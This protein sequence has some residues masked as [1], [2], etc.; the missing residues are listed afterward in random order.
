MAVLGYDK[1]GVG[2]STGDWNT[3]SFDDLAG[4]VVA[5][6]DYLKGRRDIRLRAE[7][8]SSESVRPAGSC[9]W[10]PHASDMAF[11]ISI[12]GQGYPAPRR[13]ST[14]RERND[15]ERHAATEVADIVGIMKRWSMSLTDGPR[16]G[17]VH[18]ARFEKSPPLWAARRLTCS[19]QPWT[20]PTGIHSA[21]D[22]YDPAP[23]LRR[24]RVP[25]LALFGE[26]DNNIM[27]E[28]NNAAWEAAL[29][30]GRNRD[31]TL[32][33][34]RSANH[35]QFEARTG[36]NAEMASLRRFVPAYFDALLEWFPKHVAGFPVA[37]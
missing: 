20:I 30:A 16:L 33:I 35:D 6:F 3:A 7:S 23:T 34:S 32:R 25:M 2:S 31:Y 12:S 24:L 37:R 13:R 14:R 26:L 15:R 17:R 29:K 27:A 19:R 8:E 18:R 5:A 22:F 36:S 11:L 10:P 4:D 9:R 1:R 21:V 28:K